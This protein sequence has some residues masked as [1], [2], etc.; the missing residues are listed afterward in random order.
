MA[1][2]MGDPE[3]ADPIVTFTAR[4]TPEDPPVPV[5]SIDRNSIDSL[6]AMSSGGAQ[7]GTT[8]ETPAQST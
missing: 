6:A 8:R 4:R 1:K 3:A 7:L 2:A 5:G